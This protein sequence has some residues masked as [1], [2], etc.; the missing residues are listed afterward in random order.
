V[1]II[2][3]AD[4]LALLAIGLAALGGVALAR[5]RTPLGG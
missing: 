2:P 3:E 5:R 1:P 4:S